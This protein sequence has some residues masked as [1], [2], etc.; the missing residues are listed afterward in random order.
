MSGAVRD[1]PRSGRR[2]C[3]TS[4]ADR[5]ETHQCSAVYRTADKVP[6]WT[7][8][9]AGQR[10]CLEGP[11]SS[12]G[13][14]PA[15]QRYVTTRPVSSGPAASMTAG[16]T[17]GTASA[18]LRDL[19]MP[20]PAQQLSGRQGVPASNRVCGSPVSAL[21]ASTSP[22]AARAAACDPGLPRASH[23]KATAR[24]ELLRGEPQVLE[25]QRRTHPIPAQRGRPA[26]QRLPSRAVLPGHPPRRSLPLHR[27]PDL[28]GC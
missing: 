24:A 28:G 19:A 3:R 11:S 21:S 1:A 5:P 18:R 8:S 23:A 15:G 22:I 10:R 12:P 13:G 4:V 17:G 2:R 6:A 16:A 25:R 14:P 27:D 20:H 7:A 26:H 9:A